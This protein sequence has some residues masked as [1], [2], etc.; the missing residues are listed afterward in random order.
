[1]MGSIIQD[2][3]EVHNQRVDNTGERYMTQPVREETSQMNIILLYE[4]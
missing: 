4:T 2:Q 3:A 1:M